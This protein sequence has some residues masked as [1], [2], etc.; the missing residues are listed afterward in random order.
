VLAGGG[1]DIM[2]RLIITPGRI[3][4]AV[5]TGAAVVIVDAVLRV[6]IGH[7]ESKFQK[8]LCFCHANAEQQSCS[9][10]ELCNHN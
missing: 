8:F 4:E 6:A 5:V 7:V 3:M 9:A 10:F 2:I 1:R